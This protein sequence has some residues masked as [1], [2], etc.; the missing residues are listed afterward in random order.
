MEPITMKQNKAPHSASDAPLPHER[1][2][3]HHDV[4][5]DKE[6]VIEQA[7]QDIESGQ[8][9]TDLHGMRG[10]DQIKNP[11]RHQRP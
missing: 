9:D 1:D 6:G 4:G 11:G 8:L 7:R 3:D 5:P 10:L 2:Q